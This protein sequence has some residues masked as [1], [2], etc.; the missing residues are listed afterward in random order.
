MTVALVDFVLV[1]E[2]TETEYLCTVFT[3]HSHVFSN[4]VQSDVLG[5]LFLRLFS[6]QLLS[7]NWR[8]STIKT[9]GSVFFTHLMVNCTTF[10]I[11]L[12]KV[13]SYIT[14]LHMSMIRCFVWWHFGSGH[15]CSHG[16][17]EPDSSSWTDESLHHP[18][19]N[20]NIFCFNT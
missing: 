11:H 19:M 5:F 4:L 13:S 17:F 7:C 9:E 14:Q 16:L 1:I 6:V 20:N 8:L 12:Q 15:A 10:Q 3:V 2:T 18:I